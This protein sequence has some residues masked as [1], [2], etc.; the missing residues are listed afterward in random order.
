MQSLSLFVFREWRVT[1]KENDIETEFRITLKG[2]DI[3]TEF[4]SSWLNHKVN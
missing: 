3:E 2:N 1:L 4:N